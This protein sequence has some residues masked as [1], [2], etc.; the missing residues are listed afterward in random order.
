MFENIV[1]ETIEAMNSNNCDQIDAYQ[2]IDHKVG[3]FIELQLYKPQDPSQLE[4]KKISDGVFE[5]KRK[6]AVAMMST[7]EAVRAVVAEVNLKNKPSSIVVLSKFDFVTKDTIETYDPYPI[8]ATI[9]NGE[10]VMT[11]LEK[12]VAK[13]ETYVMVASDGGNLFGAMA[14]CLRPRQ[15]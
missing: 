7:H 9:D 8:Y 4:L 10:L 5:I 13:F 6:S 11:S 1:G 3:D 12:G 15:K 14:L 2:K